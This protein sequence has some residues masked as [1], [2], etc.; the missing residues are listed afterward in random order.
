MQRLSF[1]FLHCSESSKHVS[2]ALQQWSEARGIHLEFM[3]LSNPQ[4]NAYIERYNRAVHY[5]WLSQ[6]RFDSNAQAQAYATHWLLTENNQ[7]PKTTIG[8]ITP[9]QTLAM[10]A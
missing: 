2:N 9:K 6:Y 3:Q 8:G 4:Q 1:E 5:D 10:V 7:R